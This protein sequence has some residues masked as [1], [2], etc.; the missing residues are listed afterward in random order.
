VSLL[1]SEAAIAKLRE[2]FPVF[3]KKT[4]LDNAG[5]GACCK[6]VYNAVLDYSRDYV[7]N[8]LGISGDLEKWTEKITDTKK[9]FAR[10][11]GASDEE[12]FFAPTTT[13]ALNIVA[14]MLNYKRDS[15]VVTNDME[16][17]SNVIVWLRQRAK[18]VKVKIA[19]N[20][21]MELSAET[22][23]NLVDNNTAALPVGQ[24]GWF[25]GFKHDLS[26]LSEIA[27]EKGAYLV[28]DGIQSVGGMKIDVKKEGIDFLA[29]G[30]YKW[31]LGPGGA[32]FL[33]I[34]RQLAEESTPFFIYG[35]TLRKETLERN[36]YDK[37][38]MYDLAYGDSAKR[39]D[40]VVFNRA[41]Y[42]GSWFSMNLIL[43]YG[44]E[45]VENRIRGLVEYLIEKLLSL[46]FR[47]QTP[48]SAEKRF[49]IVNFKVKD[50]RTAAK[51]LEEAGVIVAARVGGLRV[52][53]HFFN[54]KSDIDILV[55]K[56][57]K[58]GIK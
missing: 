1:P 27:H 56:V 6:Q 46:G 38:D 16:Y 13:T 28:V 9:Q 39:H 17:F 4:Y 51:K 58:L 32:A 57:Q 11:I 18:G 44:I 5:I 53:P 41:A 36:L 52:S 23:H 22:F 30:T 45:N 2:D 35:Q 14:H 24:V 26:L 54:T 29:A 47:L 37:F 25:N 15:N 21:D 8:R 10:L 3:S 20:K 43:E 19:H 31:L 49:G 48:L 34:R 7:N 12:I 42:V 33:Y 55:E 40:M 50:N